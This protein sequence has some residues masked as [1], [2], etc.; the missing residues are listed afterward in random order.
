MDRISSGKLTKKQPKHAQIFAGAAPTRFE[1]VDQVQVYPLVQKLRKDKVRLLDKEELNY[2]SIL[3]KLNNQ[4][5]SILY[6]HTSNG[7]GGD[8]SGGDEVDTGFGTNM[9]LTSNHGLPEVYKLL[10]DRLIYIEKLFVLQYLCLKVKIGDSLSGFERNLFDVIQSNLVSKS[11][12][13]SVGAKQAAAGPVNYL[14]SRDELYG[15]I[16]A[17]FNKLTLYKVNESGLPEPGTIS[18]SKL[19]EY[20]TEDKAKVGSLVMR[21]AAQ[22]EANGV[23]NLFGYMIYSQNENL[24]PIF[25]ITDFI[26]KGRKKSVKGVSCSSKSFEEIMAYVKVIEP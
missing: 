5:S 1:K 19:K 23:N 14:S 15:F 4:M 7:T 3:I 16:I 11:E 26:T 18:D 25:K 10:F 6:K 8:V 12:V 17:R 21:R 22:L 9:E 13:F 2:K 20:F 24:A